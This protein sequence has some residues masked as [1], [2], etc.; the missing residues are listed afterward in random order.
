VNYPERE[1][2][3]KQIEK[4]PEWVSVDLRD[5]NQA[6]IDPMVVS[7]KMDMFRLLV[8]LGF[9]QI[10]IGFP[11]AS[12]IEYEFLRELIEKN[13]I[14]DDVMVQVLSQCREDQIEKTFESIK[15]CKQAVV[16]IY[17]STSTL[18]RDVVFGKDRQAI[19]DI[20]V[21][22]TQWVK[23]RAEKFPGKIV[24][25]YSPESFTGTEL[26]FALEICT[27]VQDV[28]QP[29]PE[30]PMIFNLPST[31]EMTTPNVYA[32]QIEWMSRHFKDRDSIILSVHPH[33]DR[34]C[35]VAATELALLAGAQ[36]VEGTLLGNGER[37]GNVD[38]L[39]VAYNM[40]SQGIDPELNLEDINEIVE[41][42]ERC[43]K[44]SVDER[45][46]YAG[47]LVFTAFSG[48]HQDAINKG[49]TAMKNRKSKIWEVPY[50]PIDPSD[51]GRV[52]EPVVRINSQSG[53]G[54]VAFVMST[55]YGFKL[56]KGMHREF[57]DVIQ[58]MSEKQGEVPPEQIMDAFR[59][60]Y[61]YKN[62]PLH[63]RKLQV[64]DMSSDSKTDFDTKVRVVLTDH[65]EMDQFEAVG[66]G[67]LDAVQ[68]GLQIKYGMNIRILDYE[69][70]ALKSGSD[71]Q[72]AAYIH[73]MDGDSGKI[74]YGVGVSSNITRASVRA[75]FSAVNRLRLGEK[76]QGV[77][78]S[79]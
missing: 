58:A 22:G 74:T 25:E 35:G 71:S 14:P 20:A 16:H 64:T 39:T 15:G 67:P 1:W 66:N 9:K 79:F 59:S 12:Q 4:A 65:G 61:L 21:Q 51:I 38:I 34:G 69:E 42:C 55:Y 78:D 6:L 70:H 27:A 24:F 43:T 75:V 48:S 49:I 40:F 57:A 30:N 36:R 60:E 19:I 77:S 76:R 33:N 46:P 62:E 3:N 31:V 5:G 28:W 44:M 72:A 37:T 47:K 32:D 2:P 18:Q 68:R 29:T 7:E 53:K 41:V 50:L 11:A 10:E 26:D 52:Y 63:F 54:G 13:L 8:K 45:H 73:L 17:N 23:E 56:P